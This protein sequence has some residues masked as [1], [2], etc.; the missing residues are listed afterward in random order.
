MSRTTLTGPMTRS[1]DWATG[2]KNGVAL[3]NC[4]R[5][6]VGSQPLVAMR[7]SV[8]KYCSSVSINCTHART[9]HKSAFDSSKRTRHGINQSISCKAASSYQDCLFG[10]TTVLEKETLELIPIGTHLLHL[11]GRER[12]LDLVRISHNHRLSSRGA[13]H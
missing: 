11:L 9:H 12:M 1:S 13:G 5:E 7:F 2:N 10:Q 3:V 8:I 4:E 6:R